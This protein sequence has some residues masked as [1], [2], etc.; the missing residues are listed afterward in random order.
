MQI[1]IENIT[2]QFE[3]VKIKMINSITEMHRS[4]IRTPE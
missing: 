1:Y 2:F 4:T 3:G